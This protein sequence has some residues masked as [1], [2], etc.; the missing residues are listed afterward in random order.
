M[1]NQLRQNC[2]NDGVEDFPIVPG[3]GQCCAQ[4]IRK[5]MHEGSGDDTNG[6]HLAAAC[7]QGIVTEFDLFAAM[8]SGD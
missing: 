3:S 7:D 5:G 8:S 1:Q 2:A 4:S 6:R